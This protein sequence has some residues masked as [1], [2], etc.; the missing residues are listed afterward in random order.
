MYL[1]KLQR[2]SFKTREKKILSTTLVHLL[3]EQSGKRRTSDVQCSLELGCDARHQ[4]I[5][6]NDIPVA[7]KC[8]K[9]QHAES[10]STSTSS[11]KT[12]KI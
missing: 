8:C 5:C 3:C 6:T 11:R 2:T 1:Q 12:K 9:R 4:G 7:K 10:D